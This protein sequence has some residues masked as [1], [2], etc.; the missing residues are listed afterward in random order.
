MDDFVILTDSCCDMT[1]RMAADLELEV[2]PLSLNMEDRVYHNYLDGREIGFQDFYARLRAGALATTSAISVG[3][4]D[5]AMRKIL[6]SGR[7]GPH[8]LSEAGPEPGHRLRRRR[9]R[10]HE[11][12][13][14]GVGGDRR[15]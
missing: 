12:D 6:D 5:E 7:A 9:H 3:V 1:A 2:L 11:H 13:P 14:A 8:H 4:F 15:R 10:H